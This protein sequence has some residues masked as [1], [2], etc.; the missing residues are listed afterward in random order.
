MRAERKSFERLTT[1][2]S[3]GQEI[4]WSTAQQAATDREE[5]RVVRN[6]R[7]LS[8][9]AEANRQV[10]SESKDLPFV[11]WGHLRL[12]E[13]VG[14]GGFGEVFRAWEDVLHREVALKLFAKAPDEESGERMDR[15]LEEAR[16][17]ANLRHE[18]LLRV[19][20][21]EVHHGRVGFWMEFVQGESL[22]GIL[23]RQGP[24]DAIETSNVGIKLARALG[25]LHKAGV[26]H[27][28][29]K[30]E[31]VIREV[32][33]HLYLVDLGAGTTDLGDEAIQRQ[34]TPH[35]MAPEVLLEGRGSKPAD[36]YSLGV[37]LFYCAT[38]RFPVERDS[39]AEFRD[40]H[41]A[42]QRQSLGELRPNLPVAFRRV[43]ERC[44][45]VDPAKRF[46][47]AAEVED[48][49]TDSLPARRRGVRSRTFALVAVVLAAVGVWVLAPALKKSATHD[50]PRILVLPLE[51]HGEGSTYVG[52]AIAKAIAANLS[53][54]ADLNVVPVPEPTHVADRSPMDLAHEL[55]ATSVLTGTLTR[56]GDTVE[57]AVS[58][59]DAG[60][61]RVLWSTQA[62]SPLGTYSSLTS[63]IAREVEAHLGGDSPHLYG[64]PDDLTGGPEMATSKVFSEYVSASRGSS[65][66]SAAAASER[67][68]QA[69]PNELD[70]HV[71]RTKALVDVWD[72]DPSPG[73]QV[74]ALTSIASLD[75]V[76]PNNPYSEIYLAVFER[77]TGK[78]PGAVARLGRVLTRSDLSP[79]ARAWA[80][81]QQ[82]LGTRAFDLNK[83]LMELEEALV[84][85]PTNS[86]TYS[87][88][89][90]VLGRLQRHEEALVRA[91]QAV[92]L[93]PMNWQHRAALGI[94]LEDLGRLAEAATA[95]SIACAQS[96]NQ[97]P[98]ALLATILHK[99]GRRAAALAVANRAASLTPSGIGAYSLACYWAIAGDRS[100]AIRCLRDAVH[101]GWSAQ[102]RTDPDFESLHGDPEFEVIA[103]E[104]DKLLQASTAAP[105]P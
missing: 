43:V 67:L 60:S 26:L 42:A 66:Q 5:A 8:R 54:A 52:L 30:A 57:A 15:L 81:R 34:G 55:G 65:A 19:Y 25:A 46:G 61:Q 93:N 96:N 90:L 16:L 80:L 45:E 104:N 94:S 28:D 69:F 37:L 14:S 74:A 98:C 97:N 82:A 51:V 38:G 95:E 62:R 7:F 1:A 103:V 99:G 71:L 83:A 9:V 72:A 29:I 59:V 48:A 85:D 50:S 11:T 102:I 68:L 20:G 86:Y 84:L 49:L 105:P 35:Y 75:Q 33:G 4:D 87:S 31:N 24:M 17:L 100:N 91:E 41:R 39:V 58:L 3:D 13:R 92:M 70:A 73:N 27:R 63:S 76:D 22:E 2:V 56:T 44:L 47:S 6:L 78:V 53:R 18:N 23:R 64:Y 79:S 10:L 21:A 77:I 36:I 12:V 32:G 101:L 89:G 40:A 88:L